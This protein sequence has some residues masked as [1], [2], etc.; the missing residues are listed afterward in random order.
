MILAR[1]LLYRIHPPH[2]FRVT[3]MD[4]QPRSNSFPGPVWRLSSAM[5][6]V[7]M[8]NLRLDEAATAALLTYLEEETD[9][10]HPEAVQATEEHV[11]QMDHMDHSGP[12]SKSSL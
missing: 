6:R 9:R 8:P 5:P 1:Y 4:R 11:H 2:D 3:K 12:E 7:S 10:Q